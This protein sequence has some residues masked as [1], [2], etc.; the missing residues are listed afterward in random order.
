MPIEFD[1]SR[2]QLLKIG[3]LGFGA[4]ALPPWLLAACAPNPGTQSSETTAVKI[5][6]IKAALG[7]REEAKG[8]IKSLNHCPDTH[9]SFYK[10]GEG[11]TIS[12]VSAGIY[13]YRLEGGSLLDATKT[14]QVLA[15][16]GDENYA[17]FGSVLQLPG[18]ENNLVSFYHAEKWPPGSQSNFQASVRL[19]TSADAGRTWQKLGPVI[20]GMNTTEPGVRVSGA[21]QPAALIVGDEV[22]VYYTDW[23]AKFADSIQVAKAPLA[24]IANPNAYQKWHNGSFGPKGLGGESTPILLPQAADMAYTALASPSWNTHLN[25]FVMICETGAGFAACTSDNGLEWSAPQIIVPFPEPHNKR[26]RGADWYSYPTL[27]DP[28]AQNDRET[29]KD[30]VL[31]YS[32]G[33]YQTSPHHAFSQ[34]FSFS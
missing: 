11:D 26:T 21:G 16:S 27:I 23:S 29:G 12:F 13:G 33:K 6:D 15:P 19:A 28:H 32:V 25:K 3:A 30:N 18:Q 20:T 22:F 24:Q 34:A 31:L 4:T 10:N 8:V 5:G 2:R 14:E 9:T 1:P 7:K 17:A